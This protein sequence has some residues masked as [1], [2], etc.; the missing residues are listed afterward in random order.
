[1]SGGLSYTRPSFIQDG[2]GAPRMAWGGVGPSVELTE[3]L[4]EACPC[5]LATELPDFASEKPYVV[6]L[7]TLTGGLGTQRMGRPSC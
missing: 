7:R 6:S 4:K 2:H 5:P 3:A 1:M